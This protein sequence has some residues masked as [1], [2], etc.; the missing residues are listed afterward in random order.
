M[1]R[2]PVICKCVTPTEKLSK[3]L[4]QHLKGVMKNSLLYIKYSG[5][6][7]RKMKQIKKSSGK[8]YN[9]HCGCSRTVY[10]YAT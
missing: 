5:D 2:R 1:P 3:F 7:L 4:G 6:F 8:L 10:Y 9:C